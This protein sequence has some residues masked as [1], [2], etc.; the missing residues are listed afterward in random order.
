MLQYGFRS[1]GIALELVLAKTLPD[2]TADG[3]QIGQV[4][5]NLLINAQQALAGVQDER[6]VCVQTGLDPGRSS[7]DPRVWLRVSDN[8]PG[9]GNAARERVFEPFS[10]TKPDGIGTGL[11]LPVS[12]SMAREH[13]GE[14]SLEPASSQGNA[15]FRLSLLISGKAESDTLPAALDEAGTSLQARILVVDDEAELAEMMR[16][17]LESAGHEVATAES[18]ALAL[19][20]LAAARFDLVVSGLRMPVMNGAG[21]RR[22]ISAHHP[23]HP[24]LARSMLFVTGDTLSP[25]ASEFLRRARCASLDKPFYKASLLARVAELL[26]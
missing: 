6:R 5:M 11:G 25:D 8:G 9:V 4:V 2:V 13:G 22:E 23:H 20:L 10:T 14:L 16:E 18:G 17:M 21:L 3:D 1:H 24:H 12:R 15:V 26:R 19:P 7:R